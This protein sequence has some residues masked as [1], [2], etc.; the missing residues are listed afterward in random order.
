MT[1]GYASSIR[2]IST[3]KSRYNIFRYESWE[4]GDNVVVNN[5]VADLL[6]A[7]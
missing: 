4:F 6:Y 3:Y 1:A 5:M 7:C 2:C